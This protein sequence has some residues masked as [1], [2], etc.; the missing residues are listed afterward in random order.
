MTTEQKLEN[1]FLEE[2]ELDKVVIVDKVFDRELSNSDFDKTNAFKELVNSIKQ[3]GLITPLVLRQTSREN[4]YEIISGRRRYRAIQIINAND[5]QNINKIMSY[6]VPSTFDTV[7]S[8]TIAFDDNNLKDDYSKIAKAE[9]LANIF[10][11]LFYT[12]EEFD[13]LKYIDKIK[14]MSE[15]LLQLKRVC[16]NKRKD[17][18]ED[19]EIIKNAEKTCKI[20]GFSGNI[21]KL[22]TFFINNKLNVQEI[23]A[24]KNKILSTKQILTIRKLADKDNIISNILSIAVNYKLE[25]Y[26]HFVKIQNFIEER[27]SLKLNDFYDIDGINE[28]IPNENNYIIPYSSLEQSQVEKILNDAKTKLIDEYYDKSVSKKIKKSKDNEKTKKLVRNF[29]NKASRADL[30]Q[31]LKLIDELEA[32]KNKKQEIADE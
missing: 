9:T 10:L 20:A 28:F 29:I 16:S 19:I 2:I 23:Q 32:E 27:F 7:F 14:N 30:K 31:I 8:Y 15:K 1:N 22:N 13:S 18:I 26:K 6:I 21:K 24:I 3:Y 17:A 4:E 25:K 5:G 11:S 12:K